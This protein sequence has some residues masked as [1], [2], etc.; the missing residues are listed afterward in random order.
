[1]IIKYFSIFLFA[2]GMLFPQLSVARN[3]VLTTQFENRWFFDAASSNVSTPV[4]GPYADYFGVYPHVALTNASTPCYH[5]SAGPYTDGTNILSATIP[6]TDGFQLEYSSFGQP[7]EGLIPDVALGSC[8][9]PPPGVNTNVPPAGFVAVQVG[10]NEAAYYESEGG[11]AFWVPSTGRIIAAQPNNIEVDWITVT[12]GTNTQVYMASAVPASR[13]ARIF[14]TEPPYDSPMINLHGLFPVIHYNSEVPEP[15]TQV[16]TNVFGGTNITTNIVSGVWIDAQK[17]MHAVGVTGMFVLEYYTTGTYEDQVQPVGIEIVEVLPPQLTVRDVDIGERLLPKDSYWGTLEGEDGLFANITHGLDE[18]AYKSGQDGPKDGWAWAVK[19]TV[20][21]PYSLEIYWEHAGLMGVKWP[22]EVDWYSADWPQHAQVVVYGKTEDDTAPVLFPHGISATLMS[23]QEPAGHA[24]IEDSKGGFFTKADGFSLLQYTTPH[25]TWFEVIKSLKHNNSAYFDPAPTDWE[26]GKEITPM[27]D[28][29]HALDFNPAESNYIAV[30]ESFLNNKANWTFTAWVNPASTNAAFI[31]SEGNP[32]VTLEIAM[33]SDGRLHVASWNTNHA[34]NWMHFYTSNSVLT[35]GEW[36]FVGVSL[37]NAATSTGELSVVVNGEIYTGKLQSISH[38]NN[39]RAVIGAETWS[40]PIKLFDGQIE[41]VNIWTKSIDIDQVWSNRYEQYSGSERYLV[42]NFVVDEG[43]GN[44]VENYAGINDGTVNGPAN[45]VYGLRLPN[46]ASS[47]WPVYPGYIHRNE[48]KAYNVDRYNYPSEDDPAAQSYIFGVNEGELE[49]WWAEAGK[50]KDMPSTIYYPCQVQRYNN[51][52][53]TNASEIIIASGKGS[54]DWVGGAPIIYTQNNS[55]ADGYNPNEEHALIMGGKVYALRDD[56]NE[57]DSSETFVLVD[58]LNV[59]TARPEMKLFSVATTNE[60]YSFNF[61][62]EAGVA[63]VPPMP[64]GAMPLCSNSYRVIGPAW[65]DRNDAWWAKAAG[66]DGGAID[67]VMRYYY[68]MQSG[69]YFPGLSVDDQP[70]IGSEVPWLPTPSQHYGTVGYPT[71]M[72][73]NITWPTNLPEMKVAESLTMATRGLPD[74]WHQLSVELL[75]QQSVKISNKESVVLF[76]PVVKHGVDLEWS[77]VEEMLNAN[78]AVQEPMHTIYRF[79][80][81]PPTLYSRIFYDPD[82]GEDGE[83]VIEGEYVEPL[84]GPGYLLLNF[85]DDREVL[86]VKSAASGIDGQGDWNSAVDKLPISMTTIDANSPFVNAALSSGVGKGVG[87]VTVAFNNSTN[88]QQVVPSMPISLSVF[89]VIPELYNAPLEP[90]S[91]DDIM[92]ELFTMR[93]GNDFAGRVDDYDFQWRWA[94]PVGGLIPNDDFVNWSTYGSYGDI[95]TGVPSVD[96]DGSSPT[97]ALANHYFAVRY[98]LHDTANGPTGTN[99]SDWVYSLQPGW[100]QRVVDGINPY[101][102]RIQDMADNPVNM[103]YTMI[104]QAGAPYEGPI[105]LN[106]K[107]ID[108]FGLIQIYETVLERA[109]SL[110]LDAGLDDP[111]INQSILDVVSRLNDLYMLLGNEA[112][113]DAADPTIIFGMDNN[114]YGYENYATEASGMF[115]F[116]NQQ[117]NLLEE[118]LALLRGRTDTLEP[119]THLSP[120]FNRLIWNYTKGIDGGEAVYALNYDIKG[121]PANLSAT[122]T[123]ADAKLRYPQGHGDAYGYYMSALSGYYDLLIND[124]FDWQTEPGAMLI[125]NAV[126]SVDYFDER[127]F[128]ETA[129]AKAQTGVDVINHTYRAAFKETSDG[130]WQ[131]YRDGDTNRAW[132]V[133]GW[134]SRV[135]QG[136]YFDWAVGNSLLLHDLTNMMQVGGND[137]PPEGIQKIDRMT[138][139]ELQGI[140]SSLDVVQNIVDNADSGM[141]PLGLASGMVPFDI[142]PAEID[143]GKTHFEQI[144][145]RALM[146]LKN[147]KTVFDHAK[148]ASL[149]LRMQNESVYERVVA[150][151]NTELDFHNRLI[152]I[153]GRPYPD[154]IGPGKTYPEGY[155]GPDLINY[156]IVDMENMLGTHPQSSNPIEVE[157]YRYEFTNDTYDHDYFGDDDDHED[158]DDKLGDTWTASK[159]VDYTLTPKVTGKTTVWIA[160]NGLQMKPPSWTGHRPAHGEIQLAMSDYLREYYR[161]R[162]SAEVYEDLM[163]WIDKHFDFLRD[164][165]ERTVE[166][167]VW[168]DKNTGRKKTT[169]RVVEGL[170]ITKDLF[171]AMTK[172]AF[173]TGKALSE[174]FPDTEFGT[175]GPF[176]MVTVTTDNGSF[177]ELA[178]MYLFDVALVAN[179]ALEIG[180]IA[181]EQQQERWD[182]DWELLSESNDY[183]IE[184]EREKLE[185]EEKVRQQLVKENEL[186]AQIAAFNKSWEMVRKLENDGRLLMVKRAQIRSQAAHRIQEDRYSDMAFRMFRDDALQKYTAT[187]E[188]AARYVYMAAKA[189]DY[190]TGLLDSDAS[191]SSGS[192]FL[193]DIVKARSLG[194]IDNGIPMPYGGRGDPGLA[195][196]M[197]RMKADWDIVKTRFGFNNPDTET[198]RFSLRSECLRISPLPASDDNWKNVLQTYV[199]D[200]L[201]KHEIFSQYC[202]SFTSSTEPQPAIVIP[203]DTTIRFG[204]NFFGRPLAGGDNAYDASHQAT[205]IRSVGVWFTGYNNTYNTNAIGEGLSNE[206]RIYLVPAGEDV[207]RSPT[208]THEDLRHWKVMDQV[209]PLPYNIGAS[210]LDNEEWIPV[211]DSLTENIGEVRRYASLRA[212]HDSGVFVEAETHNNARL[213]GRSVWNT[214]WYLIIPGGTLLEDADEG[215][216]RFIYGAEDQDGERDGN[217][218]KDIKIFFQTYSISGQ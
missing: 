16:T 150:L 24:V 62:V 11:E 32:L 82:R 17:R 154:D 193:S 3:F 130:L 43:Q 29:T 162:A 213:V 118:E 184:I 71:S 20:D 87:Y 19:K 148:G 79:P 112:Y 33:L 199:V 72:V 1:M 159:H 46:P 216:A 27:G 191:G 53:P 164:A 123:A 207:M 104:S 172:G 44:H 35:T 158:E 217:G 25:D 14:W 2:V 209:M 142:S 37:A 178:A 157:I 151:A 160:E 64:V 68:T 204:E 84:T 203:F 140:A 42:G 89:K 187:F 5:G 194:V 147:A 73:Y 116:M 26:I 50:Q 179:H 152:E 196:I 39:D 101:E 31:Y 201:N 211:H 92:A 34:G 153:Y 180:I 59:D 114:Y 190:E 36:S 51:Y 110:S 102:Q 106:M 198:S 166:N 125:G 171:E 12:G 156:R 70:E 137:L 93:I 185:F 113:A 115:A 212:Y 181:R 74:I 215:I 78:L 18:F 119:S 167:W 45:W 95:K 149:H 163:N 126:V 145:D 8:I 10:D 200:D 61:E 141:N 60:E 77:V 81:L 195:D 76:D 121:D 63:I 173:E 174:I 100:I 57:E 139:P 30:G 183:E 117:P 15:V 146:A 65:R 120:I 49:V 210:D 144:Y 208:G 75:Y 111:S 175:T 52:W 206:P 168:L 86:Q 56:L 90:I 128:A 129:A 188:L 88:D 202:R 155:D 69:F 143:A 66:D 122:V 41:Q 192:K 124:N 131:D 23:F 169:S 99:W 4:G 55:D 161:L 6:A 127:K 108:D 83:L 98:R 58:D 103:N 218:V 97:F 105:A 38:P 170:K 91:P 176:P 96:I 135:G 186:F 107:Y 28:H 132:G 13:P 67:A 85:L 177:S 214:G 47:P 165:T 80:K 54:G 22:Y 138:T 197:A 189:Y 9:E 94:E 40:T 136:A 48:G 134:A 205:K 21:E 133:D 109:K 182:A 7:V